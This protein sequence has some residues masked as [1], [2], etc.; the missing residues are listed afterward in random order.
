MNAKTKSLVLAALS[1]A[2][3]TLVAQNAGDHPR[4]QAPPLVKALDANSDGVIDASEIAGSAAAIATL[5]ANGDGQVTSEESRPQRP[6][7][8]ADHG[9]GGPREGGPAGGPAGGPPRG[10]GSPL[11]K[12]LDVNQD[13]TL[14]ASEIAGAP[15]ALAT[16]DKN[17][18][19]QL[20]SDELHP[21]RPDG[22]PEGGRGQGGKRG[23]RGQKAPPEGQ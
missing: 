5:D 22:A 23:P 21:G 2:S 15:A 8:A 12:A 3:L 17:S 14:D 11:V 19:G 18:D 7:G 4:R 10:G 13:Q 16:L 9:Q 20:T 6:E 1:V